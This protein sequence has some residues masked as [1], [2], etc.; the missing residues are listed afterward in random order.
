VRGF[1]EAR[2]TLARRARGRPARI[3]HRVRR[4]P[5]SVGADWIGADRGYENSMICIC[6]KSERHHLH[7]QT[8][9]LWSTSIG[10]DRAKL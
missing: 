3:N 5:P 4:V 10:S 7:G 6:G 1:A 2:S 9:S 8:T